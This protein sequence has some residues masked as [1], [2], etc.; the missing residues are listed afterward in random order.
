M[1]DPAD[2]FEP[3]VYRLADM[4]G[5][6]FEDAIQTVFER[7]GWDAS[8]AERVADLGRDVIA[9]RGDET[10]IV[11]CKHQQSKISRPDI[12]KVHSAA[13]SYGSSHASADPTS[14]RAIIVSTGGFTSPAREH[15]EQDLGADTVELWDYQQLVDRAREVNV[16]FPSEEAGTAHVFRAPRRSPDEVRDLVDGSF[17]DRLDSAPRTVDDH[18]SIDPT[19]LREIPALVIEYSLDET[20]GTQTYSRLHRARAHGRKLV[21]LDDT[22]LDRREQ[23]IWD[24]AS[25]SIDCRD[26]KS[27]EELATQF[28]VNPEE[29]E[30]T[31]RRTIARQESTTVRYT[32][33][34]NQ[35]YTKECRVD[36]DDVTV[37]SRQVLLHRHAVDVTIGP[38]DHAFEIAEHRDRGSAPVASSP[39]TLDS[40]RAL[41]DGTSAILC[42]DCAAISLGTGSPS[43]TRCRDCGRT[44]CS[45][46]FWVFPSWWLWGGD[47]LCSTCYNDRSDDQ[48]DLTEYPGGS[49]ASAIVSALVAPLGLA[50]ESRWIVFGLVMAALIAAASLTAAPNVSETATFAAYLATGV[51]WF[52]AG[53]W[54]AFGIRRTSR[55]RARLAELDGYT[56]SW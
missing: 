3:A 2:Q 6:E 12:Q 30:D 18:A 53:T 43:P 13:V 26:E 31:V 35:T 47:A 29:Y 36:P 52:G 20:F 33:R 16:Y 42:N 50:R 10:V 7:R 54:I 38:G 56:P 23:S 8:V 41:W 14:T 22:A 45:E 46:H 25:F 9:R 39:L 51:T 49:H 24:D 4:S 1:A 5:F 27:D 28:G 34:N 55:H 15:A 40:T 11:E 17:L 21:T 48:P 32:G 37:R 44:L 19:D